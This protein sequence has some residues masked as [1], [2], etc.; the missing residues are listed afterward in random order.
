MNE[1]IFLVFI[2]LFSFFFHQQMLR[3]FSSAK[4]KMPKIKMGEET[5]TEEDIHF[6]DFQ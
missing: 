1:R 6:F 3:T 2:D 4:K 5:D